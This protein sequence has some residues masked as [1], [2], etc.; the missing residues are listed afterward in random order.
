MIQVDVQILEARNIV[1]NGWMDGWMDGW[2][3]V[4]GKYLLLMHTVQALTVTPPIPGWK[5]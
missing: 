4:G 3:E 1:S 2:V 5:S